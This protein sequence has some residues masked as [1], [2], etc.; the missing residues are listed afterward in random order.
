MSGLSVN[1]GS[2]NNNIINPSVAPK[3][4]FEGKFNYPVIT[5]GS[6]Q[7]DG[8]FY[9]LNGG[10]SW[11]AVD[12]GAYNTEYTV[13]GANGLGSY[14][15]LSPN[16]NDVCVWSWISSGGG[17]GSIKHLSHDGGRTWTDTY[18]GS[19]NFEYSHF[20]KDTN[21]IYLGGWAGGSQKS[22]DAGETF[23]SMTM[24]NSRQP[25]IFDSSDDENYVYASVLSNAIQ[26]S[27]NQGF[28]WTE[29][30][31]GGTGSYRIVKCS[32]S[33][34][35]VMSY[36][37]NYNCSVNLSDDYGLTY[38][39]L[40]NSSEGRADL[41]RDGSCLIY[42]A[43]TVSRIYFSINGG[44]S[45]SFIASPWGTN[46]IL[47]RTDYINKEI[48]LFSSNNNLIYRVNDDGN[49]IELVKTLDYNLIAFDTSQ[50]G[51]GFVYTTYTENDIYFSRNTQTWE[52]I[53]ENDGTNVGRYLMVL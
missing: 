27:T 45:W 39:Q 31:D 1:T 22:I 40:P 20:N 48:Y 29:V 14:M 21:N 38:T 33:G 49:N 47:T 46:K 4:K 28:S 41:R 30:S 12:T 23:T 6:N 34:Q 19:S 37:G 43:H 24:A 8:G 51:R 16:L 53:R 2:T 25:I 35:Y 50:Y 9:S 32:S 11:D 52:L 36:Y 44:S 15:N 17:G 7:H 13:I 42:T 26:R 5:L 10:R 18:Y 3:M